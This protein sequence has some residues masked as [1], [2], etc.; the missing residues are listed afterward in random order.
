MTY[1]AILVAIEHFF[2]F[3]ELGSALMIN[4]QWLKKK[5]C[6]PIRNKLTEQTNLLIAHLFF[7]RVKV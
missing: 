4:K 3:K 7:F 2:N 5:L 1:D 6:H